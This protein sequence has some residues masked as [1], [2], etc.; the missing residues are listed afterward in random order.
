MEDIIR[1]G[2]MRKALESGSLLGSM[3][4]MAGEM[5]RTGV[6]LAERAIG[7]IREIAAQSGRG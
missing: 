3:L 6:M 4:R 7:L 2:K 5:K 1:G